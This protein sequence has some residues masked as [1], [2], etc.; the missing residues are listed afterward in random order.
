MTKKVYKEGFRS[1]LAQ[2]HDVQKLLTADLD[3]KEIY[4]VHHEQESH[5]FV[6]MEKGEAGIYLLHHQ[7]HHL[8]KQ[9]QKQLNQ[10]GELTEKTCFG[11]FL[12]FVW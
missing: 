10:A 7:K 8:F 11:P 4:L 2:V 9:L 1:H 3:Q 6:D 12:A 5:G